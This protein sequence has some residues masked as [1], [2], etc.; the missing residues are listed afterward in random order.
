MCGIAGYIDFSKQSSERELHSCATRMADQIRYRGP[1]DQGVWT[2]PSA[3]IALSHRRLSIIDTS[4]CGHQPMLSSCGRYVMVFNGE[5]YNFKEIRQQLLSNSINFRGHSDTEVLLAAFS[6]LGL[7]KTLEKINGMFAIALWDRKERRL[8]LIRDRLGQKPLYYAWMGN[9]FLFASELKALKVHP[10]FNADIDRSALA[11]YLRMNYVPVPKSIYKNTFK[12]LPATHLTISSSDKNIR[13]KIYWDHNKFS[14]NTLQ[15]PFTGSEE[16]AEYILHHLLKDSVK[17]RMISDVPLG[18]FLSGGIDSSLV[19]A[20]MQSQSS[21]PVKTFTIGFHEEHFNEAN[22]ARA[23]AAHLGTEHTELYLTPKQAMD[24]IPKLPAIYD[25]PFSDMSQIPTYLVSELAKQHVTVALSGDGG[26]EFFGGYNR[27]FWVPR[28]WQRL[29][30]LPYFLKFPFLKAMTA[31]PAARWNH[32]FSKIKNQLPRSLRIPNVGD[33]SHRLASMLACRSQGEMYIDLISSWK[34]P[35]ALMLDG[36]EQAKDFFTN[37]F[38]NSELSFPHQMMYLDATTYLPDDIL[39]KVDRASMAVSLEARSPLLDYRVAEFA[40]GL[41]LSLKIRKNRGKY[42]LRK[43]LAQYLPSRLIDRP[44]MGF[45]VPMGDWLRG[46]LIPWVESLLDETR[47]RQEGFFNVSEVR[48]KWQ[49]HKSGQRNWQYCLW[50][51][52]MFQLY[53]DHQSAHTQDEIRETVTTV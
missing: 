14:L 9:V 35:N 40:W 22:E 30:S 45:G 53:L 2:D 10:K 33:K 8:Q 4:E 48:K 24:V 6:N 50:N 44:K 38:S 18:A 36:E 52:L 20:L 29:G 23:V 51:L 46:P 34:E 28:F 39:T 27:H 19:V 21:R 12:L 43:I 26:D 47:L 37:F 49:Q 7:E 42:L 16:E 25:E 11:S 41:N 31:I 1:D 3:G 32:F 17:K 5:I 15:K 13:P